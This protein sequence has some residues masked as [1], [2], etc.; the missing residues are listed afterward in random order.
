VSA[1]VRMPIEWPKSG[2]Q[3]SNTSLV[4]TTKRVGNRAVANFCTQAPF[5]VTRSTAVAVGYPGKC[6]L[7][8]SGTW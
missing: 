2:F 8:R 7:P 6:R 3:F 1:L 4:T 5:I